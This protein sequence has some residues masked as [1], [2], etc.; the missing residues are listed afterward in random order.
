MADRRARQ[1]ARFLWAVGA[2]WGLLVMESNVA[3]LTPPSAELLASAY[4]GREFFRYSVTWLGIPAGELEMILEPQ[5][6]RG[7]QFLIRVMAR[8]AGL[9]GAVYPVEDRFETLVEGTHRLPVRYAQDQQERGRRNRRLTTYDQERFTVTYVKNDQPPIVYTLD[10]PVHNEFSSFF[11][12][13]AL[14]FPAGAPPVVPTFADK[15]RHEVKVFVDK[16]ETIPSLLGEKATVQVRPHL[17]FKGLYEK[18]G[19][20]LIWLTDDAFRIPLRI[21]AKI[22]IGSLSG[23]F[24]P[25]TGALSVFLQPEALR[26]DGP[27]AFRRIVGESPEPGERPGVLGQGRQR[28]GG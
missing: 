1:G 13:R 28:L 6:R 26:E 25:G 24:F 18:I 7:E 23:R 15:K 14:P 27:A 10:G 19:D 21:E 5:G 9:L 11:F 22:V 12:L 3:A 4:Q 17:T 8:T 16:R 2:L 20:P